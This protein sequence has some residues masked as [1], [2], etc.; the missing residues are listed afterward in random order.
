MP[1]VGGAPVNPVD[2]RELDDLGVTVD[3]PGVAYA[4]NEPR[5]T[6]C[7]FIEVGICVVCTNVDRV[8][9]GDLMY[10]TV[11][12]AVGAIVPRPDL[13]GGRSR[14]HRAGAR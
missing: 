1:S 6:R 4:V 3:R 11:K 5:V 12:H 2:W 14:V 10:E 13:Q 9:H 7:L 8:S